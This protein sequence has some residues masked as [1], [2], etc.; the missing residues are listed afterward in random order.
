MRSRL[1]KCCPFCWPQSRYH[2]LLSW[3]VKEEGEEEE[4]HWDLMAPAEESQKKQSK[5]KLTI[6]L[7]CS[8]ACLPHNYTLHLMVCLLF[9][10]GSM[11][12]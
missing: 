4:S 8:S 7:F 2:N 1:P 6:F 11:E 10:W 12:P 3:E 5:T 9:S